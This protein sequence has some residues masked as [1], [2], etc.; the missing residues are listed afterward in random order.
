MKIK[1]LSIVL[2]IAGFANAQNVFNDSFGTYTA[3]A[4]LNGQGPWTN[5]SSLPGGLGTS[6]SSCAGPALVVAN[7]MSYAGYGSSANSVEIKPN[8]D[9]C[10]VQ[11]PGITSQEVYVAMVINLTTVNVSSQDFFRVMS[12]DNFNTAFRMTLKQVGFGYDVGI[13][14]A[15]SGNPT[16][17]TNLNLTLGVDNL[18]VLRFTQLPGTSDDIVR[19]FVN[20][21]F[22]AG[23]PATADATMAALTNSNFSDQSGNV[24][25]MAFRQNW[26]AGMPTGRVGLVSVAKS[27][28]GL[29]FSLSNNQIND[30]RFGINTASINA[31]KLEITSDTNIQDAKISIF[32]MQGRMI[33]S[34]STILTATRNEVDVNPITT[35]GVYILE[36]TSEK[37]KFTQKILVQ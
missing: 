6:C 27:W 18:V 1:L 29:T 3:A 16:A 7:A 5:N 10:G 4:Q 37:G 14:K 35:S 13:A 25:R 24:D 19:A 8:A 31:G 34:K 30:I 32:D 26:T 17:F 20:P 36:I 15:G 2:L 9:G 23:E 22:L 21:N 28:A 33:Y 11:F 12:G